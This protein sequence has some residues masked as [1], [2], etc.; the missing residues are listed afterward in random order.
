MF[1]IPLCRP[2]TFDISTATLDL[3]FK[4]LQRHVHPDKFSCKPKREQEASASA[5]SSI[6]VAYKILRNPA[7]RA[8]YLLK[9][10]GIDAIGEGAGSGNVSPA[11]LM[12]VMEAREL[13]SDADTPPDELV[14]LRSRNAAAVDACVKDLSAAFKKQD[15]DVAKDIVVALQYYVKLDEEI[16]ERLATSELASSPSSVSLPN[17]DHAH[18]QHHSSTLAAAG[19]DDKCST[20]ECAAAGC[21]NAQK[22]RSAAAR[23]APEAARQQQQR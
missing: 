8:Q 6:N 15:L 13:V 10:G 2:H 19:F 4:R 18:P 23:L 22:V 1:S 11:L 21:A 14:Q 5:S 16:E 9:L 20:D 7:S 12:Q 17:V 3:H